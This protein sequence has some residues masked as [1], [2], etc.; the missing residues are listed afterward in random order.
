MTKKSSTDE[1]VLGALRPR[2]QA[3]VAEIAAAVKLSR[4]TV[5]RALVELERSGKVGRS[6]SGHEGARRLPDL[7]VRVRRSSRL[8][9]AGERLRPGELDGLVLGYLRKHIKEIP[10][11]P[12]AVA[13][14]LGRSSGAVGNCMARLAAAG[15]VRLVSERPRRYTA[16][17]DVRRR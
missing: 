15:S 12:S 2:S 9:P 11:G 14:G 10:L 5:S 13:Q 16:A 6:A 3:T 4:S 7:W 17:R 1:V 8:P